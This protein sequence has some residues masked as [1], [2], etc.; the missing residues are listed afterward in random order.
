MTDVYFPI[1]KRTL[2]GKWL[3]AAAR[4]A[5]SSAG[6][7]VLPAPGDDVRAQIKIMVASR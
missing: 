2:D 1:W 4:S 6:T 7:L 3:K 5:T